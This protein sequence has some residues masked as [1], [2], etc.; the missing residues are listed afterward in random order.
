[1]FRARMTLIYA[2]VAIAGLLAFVPLARAQDT[3]LASVEVVGEISSMTGQTTITVNGLTINIERAE[4]K[5]LLA[6]GATV[7][8]E[9]VFQPDGTIL[10]REVKA[11]EGGLQ[12]GELE[13]VGALIDID[14]TSAALDGFALDLSGTE[15]APGLAAG[16][17]V[18]VHAR[19]GPD[20]TWIV[21]EIEPFD[22]RTRALPAGHV[23]IPAGA[24]CSECHSD[25][26]QATLPTRGVG[27]EDGVLWITGTLEA[28]GTD[29]LVVAGQRYDITA[30]QLRGPLVTGTLVTF[31][32]ARLESGALSVRG[33]TPSFYAGWSDDHDDRYDDLYD[34]DWDDDAYDDRDDDWN[35]GAY[36][37]SNDDG[38]DDVYD[39]WDDDRDDDHDDDGDDD[40]DDDHDNDHD[41]W[42]D[43]DDD[44]DD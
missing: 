27:V 22:L 14:A 37:D 13:I 12:A 3:P 35:D 7:K 44:D 6:V 2:L 38:D 28:V 33:V 10:A 4:R 40:S 25:G 5:T 26:R 1:M 41:D 20:G 11:A 39:D 23:A 31:E 29:Y 18:K 24:E 30:A 8:V 9:G 19:L 16:T 42:G 36:D 21:R 34:D 32:L 43:E 17:L 15:V